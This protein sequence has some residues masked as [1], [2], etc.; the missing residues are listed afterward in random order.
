MTILDRQQYFC[1][2]QA[3]MPQLLK[4]VRKGRI[5]SH[6]G[7]PLPKDG[8]SLWDILQ[9]SWGKDWPGCTDHRESWRLRI[10]LNLLLLIVYWE[11]GLR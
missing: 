6:G 7:S 11:L 8:E 1:L 2:A 4:L 10:V 3:V 5:N 9:P